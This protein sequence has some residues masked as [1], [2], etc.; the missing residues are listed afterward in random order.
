MN[1][2]DQNPNAIKWLIGFTKGS[3]LK[4]LLSVLLAL[5]GVGFLLG[6]YVQMA[7]LITA[8]IRG[9]REWAFYINLSLKIILFWILRHLFHALST[10]LSHHTTFHLLGNI[11]RE[12]L[13]KLARLPLGT[14]QERPSGAYKNTICE[15]VDSIE[16]TL[17][18]ILPEFTANL[19]GAAAFF[20]Y[21][22]K[23]DWRLGLWSLV[24]LPLGL[25]LFGVM[26]AKMPKYY[27]ATIE[28]TKALNAAAVEY[29]NGI[30]VIKV[31]GQAKTSYG[32]FVKAAREGAD[33]FIDWMRSSLF[34]MSFGMGLLPATLIS[35]L[36]AGVF[37]S[38]NGTLK[39]EDFV[40]AIILSFGII[41]PL[42]TVFSYTDDLTQISLIMSDVANIMDREDL[43]RP[44]KAEKLP[45]DNGISLDRVTFAYEEKEVLHGINMEIQPGSVNA[46]AGPSGSGK[47]TIAKLIASLWDVKDGSI[48]IGGV[49]IR[50]LPLSD[51]HRRIAYVAQ[52]NYLF[53]LS[54]MDNIRLGRKGASDE[55]VMEAARKC[56]CHSFIMGLEHGYDTL[57]GG[58]GGHLSGGERQRI[59]IARAML[60]DAP[61]II[62]D[63]A[64]SYTDPESEA[65]LQASLARLIKGKTVLL[66]AHRLS[67]ITEVDRIFVVND[68]R[69]EAAGLHSELLENCK[70]YKDM[71][72]AHIS[73]SDPDETR[74]EAE[75]GLSQQPERNED[76]ADG[77][78]EEEALS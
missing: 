43:K 64:T 50:N 53:N 4:Y 48:R 24:T 72:E 7:D 54:V 69:I 10:T 41:S 65:V 36:P 21:L 56:G 13:A 8:L 37:Y 76:P 39:A 12:I 26:M 62:L 20:I 44:E 57:C 35:V 18:H 78:R 61:I 45:K 9:N 71:W 38:L 3:R 19:A 75:D 25:V 17:A 16:T 49:D 63:E 1:Q 66:I 6:A 67:T 30:E 59:A 73:L 31:F 40:F 5:A 32:K 15:R 11:R 29:I 77:A 47:S 68:G 51:Y 22:L 52:D 60:K 34:E 14:V 46:L 70:L 27:P 58:S 74:Q 42:L 2:S 28:K 33:C 23:V 55:E